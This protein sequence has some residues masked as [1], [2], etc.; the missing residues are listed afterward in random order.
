M[1][2]SINPYAG[3]AGVNAAQ[4]AENEVATAKAASV[5]AQ[6]SV[7]TPKDSISIS[8]EGREKANKLTSEQVDELWNQQQEQLEKFKLMLQRMLGK[9]AQT[10]KIAFD[11]QTDVQKSAEAA[12]APG[13]E[14][15]V[16]AVATRI[17]N[18]AQALAGGDMT[19]LQV[20]KDA[21]TEGFR[22]VSAMFGGKGNDPIAG[23]PQ[24]SQDTYSEI[25]TRFDEWQA[26]AENQAA[27]E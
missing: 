21:V 12:I 1:S 27:A 18:M 13:G 15:S 25:M 9:Q 5:T 2:I 7:S 8:K 3:V 26:S 22:Q 23:L 20:L 4:T 10:G 11:R 17:M 14:Y 16:D 24:V 19:K 6:A